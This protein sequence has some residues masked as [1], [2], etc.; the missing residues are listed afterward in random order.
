MSLP[1]FSLLMLIT[2]L[3]SCSVT[4]SQLSVFSIC[5]PNSQVCSELRQILFLFP[6]SLK[7]LSQ[8][9][10]FFFVFLFF[11]I[12]AFIFVGVDL[13]CCT[14]FSLVAIS[15]APPRCLS[16]DGFSYCRA[17]ALGLVGSLVAVSG[18]QSTGSVVVAHRLCCSMAY[19]ILPDQGS[20]R[21]LLH[22]QADS[23]PLSHQG[24]PPWFCV[25]WSFI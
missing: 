11:L 13:L 1:H 12:N 7:I 25:T 9:S 21:C 5:C 24:S 16:C 14:S 18:S 10:L 2:A 8:V 3:L 15:G 6:F 20:N 19:G 22:L 23:L 4:I 17:R